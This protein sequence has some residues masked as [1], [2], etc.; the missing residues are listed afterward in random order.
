MDVKS[1]AY[2]TR[3]SRSFFLCALHR[4]SCPLDFY[5]Y[6]RSTISAI[7]GMKAESRKESNRVRKSVKER[8]RKRVRRDRGEK[9]CIFRGVG[10]GGACFSHSLP[11]LEQVR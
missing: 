3:R 1:Y 4:S 10:Q 7:R 2:S 5:S 9:S 8:E 11:S 6:K